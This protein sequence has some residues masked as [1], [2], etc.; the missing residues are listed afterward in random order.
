MRKHEYY[1]NDEYTMG[2][3]TYLHGKNLGIIRELGN[4]RDLPRPGKDGEG[5][6]VHPSPASLSRVH[7]DTGALHK[8]HRVHEVS[9]C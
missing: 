2:K 9:V 7:L 5:R 8:L 3:N 4:V 6:V 1:P